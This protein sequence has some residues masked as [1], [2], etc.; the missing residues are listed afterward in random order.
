MTAAESVAFLWGAT[1]GA[2]QTEGNNTM[3]DWWQRETSPGSPLPSPSGDAADS[4]HRWRED[5]D[6]VADS[7]LTDYRFGIEWARIEPADGFISLAEVDHYRRMVAGAFERGL[8]PMPTLF[9]FTVPAWFAASGG[10]HR[11][12]AV[13]RFLRYVEAILPVL[14]DGVERV[15]TINEPNIYAVLA[16]SSRP[17][18]GSLSR[19]LPVPDPQLSA[20]MIAAHD[21]VRD[22]LRDR[23]PQIQSGWGISVQDYQAA[24]GAEDV[25]HDYVWPRDEVFLE[26]SKGDDWVGIQTYT[27]GVIGKV[28][29]LPQPLINDRSPVTQTGWEDYPRALGG[30]LKRAADVL[31]G[32]PLIVTENGIATDDDERRIAFTEAA[33]QSL[34]EAKADGVNVAGYFH[35]SLLDNYEWG[36][37]GPR[38]G[39]VSVDRVTFQ[40]TAKPSLAWLGAKAKERLDEH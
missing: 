20:K 25:F 9:H 10:W 36:T 40:R 37:F 29:G 24:E 14:S 2:H 1:T 23:L 34:W 27:R 22:F 7:G 17:G 4:Y 3:S 38:F 32:V 30:A 21:A 26:A 39:L 28:D 12:D 31:G 16:S 15:E 19:G 33:L 6:L 8:R 35:W 18:D 5:M 11:D 13:P